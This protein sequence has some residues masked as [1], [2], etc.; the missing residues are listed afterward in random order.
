MVSK[1]RICRIGRPPEGAGNLGLKKQPLRFQ[2]VAERFDGEHGVSTRVVDVGVQRRRHGVRGAREVELHLTLAVEG[3]VDRHPDWRRAG[4]VVVEVV[5]E[6]IGAGRYF[7]QSRAHVGFRA[8]Q[9]R[10]VRPVDQ[11]GAIAAEQLGQAHGCGEV[12]RVLGQQVAT[13]LVRHAH[14]TQHKAQD[15][16]VDLAL[17]HE[18]HRQDAQPFLKRLGHP[19]HLLRAWGRP[20]HVDLMR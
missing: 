16:L 18:A 12:G 5:L 7:C 19:V 8:I 20:T 6:A 2:G 15:I 14:I 9:N 17:A 4:T 13:H 10:L 3:D 11:I 1:I